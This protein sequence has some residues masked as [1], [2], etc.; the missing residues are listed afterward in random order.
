MARSCSSSPGAQESARLYSC[1]GSGLE[2][3]APSAHKRRG[4]S[5]RESLLLCVRAFPALPGDGWQE[6][7]SAQG[8]A[9]PPGCCPYVLVGFFHVP[10]MWCQSSRACMDPSVGTEQAFSAWCAVK[11]HFSP[12][13]DGQ[14]PTLPCV[15]V[16]EQCR[17]PLWLGATLSKQIL[18]F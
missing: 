15:Y 17:L 5:G 18:H 2:S 11:E 1:W 8:V 16:G 4:S 6:A 10:A 3:A 9:L 14:L 7:A 13:A 12:S